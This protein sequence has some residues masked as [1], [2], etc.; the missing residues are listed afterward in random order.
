YQ[1]RQPHGAAKTW[2][3]AEQHFRETETRI[4]DRNAIVAGKRDFESAAETVAMDHG[5][6]GNR[7]A[8]ETIDDS[9]RLVQEGFRR[10]R[11]SPGAELADVG[12]RHEAPRLG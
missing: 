1:S 4:I 11:I 12:S 7:E 8:V 3:Q 6:D 10:A 5:H 9:M 2:M